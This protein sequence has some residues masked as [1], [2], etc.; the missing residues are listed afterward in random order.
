LVPVGL[1]L[2][3][4]K[5]HIADS[6]L[7]KA[8]PDANISFFD[9]EPEP[10]PP[11]LRSF[12]DALAKDAR[13]SQT[14]KVAERFDLSRLYSYASQH[15]LTPDPLLPRMIGAQH[16]KLYPTILD[17]FA[18]SGFGLPWDRIEIVKVVEDGK[19]DWIVFTR[20]CSGD[21]VV[22]VKWW[23]IR[24]AKGFTICDVENLLLKLRVSQQFAL[25]L[26]TG[27]DEK[28]ANDVAEA[29]KSIRDATTALAN[30][31]PRD[32]DIYLGTAKRTNLPEA[33]KQATLA[34]EGLIAATLN[35]GSKVEI[36]ATAFGDHP[37]VDIM[38]AMAANGDGW[39]SKRLASALKFEARFGPCPITISVRI[40][41]LTIEG[42][43]AEASK[44]LDEGLAKY[45]DSPTLFAWSTVLE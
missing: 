9:P 4:V 25:L 1:E 24:N 32:A 35:E 42:K 10:I 17:A 44:L 41:S 22:P 28:R 23:L 39:L 13:S 26:G 14:A 2:F 7:G 11:E 36:I 3:L 38:L 27:M 21:R 33:Q 18:R 30:D 5:P 16:S 19:S 40:Q 34:L 8:K 15:D 45:P 6:S 12:F 43:E 20:N 31:K 29:V 37:A